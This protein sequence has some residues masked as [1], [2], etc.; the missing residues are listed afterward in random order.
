MDWRSGRASG[1][2]HAPA[3]RGWLS[4][5]SPKRLRSSVVTAS[6]ARGQHRRL[7]QPFDRLDAQFVRHVVDMRDDRDVEG[8]RGDADVDVAERDRM[9]RRRRRRRRDAQQYEG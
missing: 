4:P 3:A 7:E 9:S 2:D 5:T 1:A 8:G 6:A